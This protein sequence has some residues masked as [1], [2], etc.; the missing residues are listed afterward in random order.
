MKALHNM[1]AFFISCAL[2][3]TVFPHQSLHV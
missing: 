3:Q 2:V 1:G